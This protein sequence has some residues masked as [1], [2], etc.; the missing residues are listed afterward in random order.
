[1]TKTATDRTERILQHSR[2]GLWVVLGMLAL[3]AGWL[4][5]LALSPQGESARTITRLIPTLLPIAIVLVAAWT[6]GSLGGKP[7]DPKEPEA[8]AFLEDELRQANLGKS[9]RVAFIAVLV[10][11]PLLA[12]FLWQRPYGL[13]LMGAFTGV[14]AVGS[15]VAAFL[16]FD[17]D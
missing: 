8:R 14:L 6:R 9:F 10:G 7:F 12:W 5:L 11:Q 13:V 1:M 3:L 16:A 15:L 4:V 2:R 17:R